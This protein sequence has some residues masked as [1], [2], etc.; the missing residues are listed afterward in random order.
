MTQLG[1][2]K[3]IVV[4]KDNTTI[5]GGA[6][7]R[8]TI[9]GRIERIRHEIDKTTQRL[10]PREAA[11]TSGKTVGRRGG[12]S[13]RRTVRGGNEIEEGSARR[14]DQR[15][16]GSGRRG[17]RARRWL[18]VAAL[19]RAPSRGRSE[20]RGRRADRV[21]NSQAGARSADPSDRREFRGR[22]R[23]RRRTHA[24]GP[25]QLR[26]RRRA[27]ASMSIWSRPASSIRPRSFGWHWKTPS[28]SPACYC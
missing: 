3:R 7:D 26:L 8:K 5:I 11:G 2:A 19:H 1:R 4:D 17:H 28:R 12:D 9:D 10:R 13:G 21:A 25:G 27:Q 23:R 24:G 6:G 14:R 18:G 15:D 22:R 20:M 16:Q